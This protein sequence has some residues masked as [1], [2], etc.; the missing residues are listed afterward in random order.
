[1][2]FEYL[3]PEPRDTST[4]YTMDKLGSIIMSLVRERGML[5]ASLFC[6]YARGEATPESDIDLVVDKGPAPVRLQRS[7]PWN[8]S[9]TYPRQERPAH[10]TMPTAQQMSG[11]VIDLHPM[12]PVPDLSRDV[13][14]PAFKSCR[15]LSRA[16]VFDVPAHVDRGLHIEMQKEGHVVDPAA[17]GIDR[18]GVSTGRFDNCIHSRAIVARGMV[19]IHFRV[20]RTVLP[21]VL[22]GEEGSSA[23]PNVH[24]RSPCAGHHALSEVSALASRLKRRERQSQGWSARA[25][26][27]RRAHQAAVDT[28]ILPARTWTPSPRTCHCLR[29]HGTSHCLHPRGIGTASKGPCRSRISFL[30]A[31]PTDGSERFLSNEP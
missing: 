20:I 6:S 4:V 18:H 16:V 30:T 5:S 27:G 15:D 14:A 7:R 21:V 26:G 13:R 3:H 9:Y 17:A 23:V 25:S 2:S 12:L 8:R 31:S 11:D 22:D 1:M 24:F 29:P 19:V 10:R 28:Y